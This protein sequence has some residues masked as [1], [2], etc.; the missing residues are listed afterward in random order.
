MFDDPNPTPFSDSFNFS[1]YGMGGLIASA[2]AGAAR[3][4]VDMA[5]QIG[6]PT[7]TTSVEKLSA[8]AIAGIVVACI[9]ALV[10]IFVT[11]YYVIFLIFL[12]ILFSIVKIVN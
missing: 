4:S 2:N 10:A 8:A 9:V 11:I 6:T 5:V 7:S 12:V 3:A 1:E